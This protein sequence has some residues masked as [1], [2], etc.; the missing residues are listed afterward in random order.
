MTG[1]KQNYARKYVIAIDQVD[2]A[3][4]VMS[5]PKKYNLE[6]G[7]EDGAY[8]Y[9]LFLEG[10]RW[11]VEDDTLSESH[12]K[13]L[14]TQMPHIWLKPM[15]MAEIERGHSYQCPIYKT[16]RRAGTLSTTGHSTNFVMHT[17]LPMQKKHSEKHWV[18][19][20]VALLTQL[21]D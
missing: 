11:S 16:S 13:V 7:A 15:K 12:P 1:I 10:C 5:D 3:F 20:G 2:F 18:K 19:R 17:F 21:N 14:Y 9:G 6:Q 4:E 8:I